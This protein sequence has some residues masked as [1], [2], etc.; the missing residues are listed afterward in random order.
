MTRL[1]V[2]AAALPRQV[3]AVVVNHG[4]FVEEEDV[5]AVKQ[6]TML[7]GSDND[8]QISREKLEGFGAILKDKAGV[9]SDVKVRRF[10][11]LPQASRLFSKYKAPSWRRSQRH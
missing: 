11:L 3:K 7:N 6:P 2:T 5:A 4:S 8:Q 10:S 1:L 9:Q